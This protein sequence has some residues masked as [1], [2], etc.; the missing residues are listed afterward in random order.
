MDKGN[1][2]GGAK[3]WEKKQNQPARMVLAGW[4]AISIRARILRCPAPWERHHQQV[5]PHLAQEP[6]EY[7]DPVPALTQDPVPAW[8]A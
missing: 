2:P 7:Q 8:P 4:I 1:K 3:W 5:D 6:E